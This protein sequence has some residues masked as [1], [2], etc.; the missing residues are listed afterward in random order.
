M[1]NQCIGQKFRKRAQT[2][3]GVHPCQRSNDDKNGLPATRQTARL[4]ASSCQGRLAK[5]TEPSSGS[6]GS[7]SLLQALTSTFSS[8]SILKRHVRQGTSAIGCN[9]DYVSHQDLN[10]LCKH[11]WRLAGPSRWNGPD[12]GK[13]KKTKSTSPVNTWQT[14]KWSV[15]LLTAHPRDVGFKA[16]FEL[17]SMDNGQRDRR[18]KVASERCTMLRLALTCSLP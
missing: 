5:T 13:I 17:I 1:F 7:D 6:H 15:P 4:G 18:W 14:C 12:L 8:L 3:S 11:G 2:R 10:L 9:P 16:W